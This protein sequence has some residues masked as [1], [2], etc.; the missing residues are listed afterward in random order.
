MAELRVQGDE[1]VED[2]HRAAGF[3]A[4]IKVGTR[5][6]GVVE[7][8][9]V[10]KPGKKTF[11]AIHRDTPQGVRIRLEGASYDEWIVACRDP[12]AVVAGLREERP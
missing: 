1:L 10:R 12:E 8:G 4:G 5:I 6:P 11:V 2:A 9:T 3:R 7:V